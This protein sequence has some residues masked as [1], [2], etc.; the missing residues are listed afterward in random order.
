MYALCL[1]PWSAIQHFVRNVLVVLLFFV[2][3]GY[4]WNKIFIIVKLLRKWNGL[5]MIYYIDL[6]A[7]V[8]MYIYKCVY[9]I[10]FRMKMHLKETN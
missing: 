1:K 5:N 3:A 9:K 8:C 4:K 6:I 10:Y 2:P 7:Y